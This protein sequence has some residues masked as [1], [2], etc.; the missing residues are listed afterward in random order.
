MKNAPLPKNRIPIALAVFV[1]LL[2]ISAT[3]ASA[4][5]PDSVSYAVTLLK[6]EPTPA[7]PGDIVEAW[8]QI[9][10]GG[11]VAS[12]AVTIVVDPSYPFTPVGPQDESVNVGPIAAASSYVT[13]IKLVVDTAATDGTYTLPI[14]MTTD[15]ISYISNEVSM[16]VRTSNSVLTVTQA[17]TT[18]AEII[19]GS[20]SQF[21]VTVRNAQASTLRDVTVSLDLADT[22][23]A[24]IGTTT[25]QTL[26]RIE[27]GAQTTFR[28][29]LVADPEAQSGIARIP[30][31]FTFMN[32]D[33]TEVTQ[34]ETV[35]ILVHA[36]PDVTVLI[37]RVTRSAD[38]KEL[39]V[40]TRII[41]KG[42]SQVK[43]AEVSVAAADGYTVSGRTEVYVGNI[44]SDDFQTAEFTIKPTGETAALK[45]TLTYRD[46]LNQP[47]SV[48]VQL[49]VVAPAKASSGGSG[50]IVVIVVAVLVVIGF[51]VF[52]R[53]RKKK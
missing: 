19:P 37:D 27:G 24:T 1:L 18:P 12:P 2:G 47:Y 39:I 4:A 32:A 38:E 14:R 21:E 11:R 46:A 5:S 22:D 28:F 6:Y 41:N 36:K 20:Q 3:L 10:N 43:F 23:L 8:V 15:G 45:G 40:L 51:V 17:G 49:S 7:Q 29:Q 33:G 16:Q 44:D 34:T 30:L 13:R 9:T 35:G 53:S 31:T 50:I 25:K 26:P 52:R 48:P 42:L